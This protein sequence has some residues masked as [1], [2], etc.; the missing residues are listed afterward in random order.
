M[1]KPCNGFNVNR[2]AKGNSK[3]KKKA[4]HKEINADAINVIEIWKYHCSMIPAINGMS[5][6]VNGAF[7]QT[8]IPIG[9]D[10]Q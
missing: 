7:F 5:S 1:I 8:G 2:N 4:I 9:R 6:L 3:N 10:I